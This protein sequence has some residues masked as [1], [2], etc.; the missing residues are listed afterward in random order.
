MSTPII[1]KSAR[2]LACMLALGA[3][4]SARA[5]EP[6]EEEA[7]ETP[8]PQTDASLAPPWKPRFGAVL[9]VG[10]PTGVG[11]SALVHP[12]RW[13]RVH[14]GATRNT[15]GFGVRGGATIIPLELFVS[16]LLELEVGRVFKA[17]YGKLLSQWKDEPTTSATSLREVGYSHGSAS[18][19]LQYSPSPYVTLFGAVGI[20]A[21][22]LQVN[23]ARDFI[24]EAESDPDIIARPVTLNLTSPTLKLGL[25]VSFD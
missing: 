8:T 13:L 16:P 25:L 19:G 24:R 3:L 14:L 5:Q 23:E 7:Q 11:V 22:S 15:L 2:L 6:E 12:L 10:A 21:W 4:P 18:L 20:S 17:D 1:P 9:D